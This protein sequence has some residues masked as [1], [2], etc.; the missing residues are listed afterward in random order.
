M[1]TDVMQTFCDL[2]DTGS[3]SKAAQANYISQSA[4]SQQLAKL[5][6]DLATQLVSRGG[7]LVEP[8]EAG[9]AFYRG[10]KEILRRYEHLLGEVRSAT[11]A[12]RGVLRVGTIYSVGF[13][14]LEPFVRKFLR[15]HPEVDL[16]MEYTHGT[17]VYSAI[18]SGEMDL[19]V[20]AFPEKQRSI[21]IVPLAQ[22]ELVLVCSP[23]HRLASK[24]VVD[25]SDLEGEDFVGFAGGIPTRRFI[26]RLLKKERVRVNIVMEFD[27]I[28]L[29]KRAVEVN[30]GISILPRDN[31]GREVE[32][33]YLSLARFRR[34]GNWV[35]PL[36]ILRRRGKATGPAERMFLGILHANV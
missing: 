8:T 20:V 30:A 14:L 9:K 22:E 19:G 15:A 3:F 23:E 6:R 13:Y 10:A 4:V 32:G 16:H 21:E 35:R 31:I 11:D 12:V 7:G 25:P 24:K 26:D 27:N 28:E 5:E 33:G 29:L 34:R 2:V 18:I 17:R 1:N 36:G